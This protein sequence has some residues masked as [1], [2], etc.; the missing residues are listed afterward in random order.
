MFPASRVIN[1]AAQYYTP[2]LCT[3]IDPEQ[4]K[5]I[6]NVLKQAVEKGDY[7]RI[8]TALNSG[9]LKTTHALLDAGVNKTKLSNQYQQWPALI[10]AQYLHPQHTE[11]IKLLT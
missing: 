2:S 6:D 9:Q 4:Q 11:L 7:A 5:R 10:Y 3:I 1:K 8:R